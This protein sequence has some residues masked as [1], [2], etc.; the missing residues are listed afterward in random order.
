M[1]ESQVVALAVVAQ[2]MH[3]MGVIDLQHWLPSSLVQ[4]AGIG[5]TCGLRDT[6]HLILTSSRVVFPGGISPGAGKQQTL[7]SHRWSTE[8]SE[9]LAM[10]RGNAPGV[11]SGGRMGYRGSTAEN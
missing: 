6:D 2:R 5:H 9:A 8:A 11:W 1:L 3:A 7:L 4:L 10:R